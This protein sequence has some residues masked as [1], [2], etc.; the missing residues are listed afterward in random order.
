MKVTLVP[1]HIAPVGFAAILTL[2]GILGF[3][4]MVIPVE[5]AGLPVKQG[6]AFDVIKHVI[7]SEF[8]NVVVV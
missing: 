4:V 8:A 2:A 5:V 6:V 1:E 3:T 7:T